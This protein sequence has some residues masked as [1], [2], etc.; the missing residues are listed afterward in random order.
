MQF[1]DYVT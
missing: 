1:S